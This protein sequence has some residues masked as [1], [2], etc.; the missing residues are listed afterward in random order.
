MRIRIAMS[1]PDLAVRRAAQILAFVLAIGVAIALPAMAQSIP[2]GSAPDT[3]TTE[4]SQPRVVDGAASDA[5]AK[6]GSVSGTV[7]DKSGAV[8]PGAKVVLTQ[9]GVAAKEAA[10]GNDGSFIFTSVAPGVFELTVKAASF[11]TFKTSG[12][13]HPG[14]ELVLP[15]VQMDVGVQVQ[16][17]VAETQEQIAEEQVH[18]EERQ[19]LLG[20]VPNFYVTYEPH[21]VPLT[22]RQKFQLA[23]KSSIDPVNLGISAIFAGVEQAVDAFPGYGQGAQGYAKRFGANYADNFIG[24]FV[25]GAIFPSILKQDP[26]YFYKGTGTKKQRV[27]YAL[28]NAFICKGDN[29]RWQPNYSAIL[30]GMAAGGI[31]NLYYPASNRNGLGLTFE[32]AGINIGSNAINNILQEFVLKR[33]TPHNPDTDPPPAN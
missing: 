33:F 24:T 8:I 1:A 25:G 12:T 3:S 23:W 19:R 28:A 21:A 26:R 31:S 7:A 22:P 15:Q 5:A 9:A 30:G 16:I 17:A 20:I 27:L 11:A 18:E 2:D 6:S 14:Q 10:S 4:G 13:L 29:G 32:N